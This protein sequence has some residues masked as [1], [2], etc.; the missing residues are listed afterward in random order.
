MHYCTLTDYQLHQNLKQDPFVPS[1]RQ[2]SFYNIGFRS[3][4][5]FV[6]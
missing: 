1:A 6:E 2:D 3:F 5:V 4:E